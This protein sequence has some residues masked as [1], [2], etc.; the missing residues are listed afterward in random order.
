MPPEFRTDDE[1][2]DVEGLRAVQAMLSP[3]GKLTPES[4]AA[5]RKVLNIS[6][7]S[8]RTA[9]IDLGKTYT[10]EFVARYSPAGRIG[11]YNKVMHRFILHNDEIHEA[12]DHVL[13]REPSPVNECWEISRRSRVYD[14]VAFA[15]ERPLG[16]MQ[17]DTARM[18]CR[19]R[20][21]AVWLEERLRRPRRG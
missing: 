6:L 3:D 16:A 12:G 21:E 17:R 15:W 8:V 2:V 1:D 10:N 19:F 9:S 7:D 18:G 13:V 11:L 4:A 5:V 20:K 14:G